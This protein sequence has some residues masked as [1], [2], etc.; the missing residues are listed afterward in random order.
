[1]LD[2]VRDLEKQLPFS[3]KD[4][5]NKFLEKLNKFKTQF[6]M[7]LTRDDS[8]G[9]AKECCGKIRK[10]M[11]EVSFISENAYTISMYK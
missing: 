3:A 2:Y 10:L 11:E 4:L 5:Y 1:M 7:P 6:H 9:H 8:I